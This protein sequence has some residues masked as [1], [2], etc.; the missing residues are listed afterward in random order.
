MR[1]DDAATSSQLERHNSSSSG[2]PPQSPTG[3]SPDQAETRAV[4]CTNPE[5]A[6]IAAKVELI[7]NWTVSK[8]KTSKQSVLEQLGKVEK[9]I[10][11]DMDNR[12]ATLY[13]LRNRY[14]EI[15]H[16][17]T[18]YSTHF[19]TLNNANKMLAESFYQ[20]SLR[21][22][23]LKEALTG[24]NE[25]L[26]QFALHADEF[27]KQLAYFVSSMETLCN[28]TI[29]DT[30]MTVQIYENARLEYDAHRHEL[31]L[32]Q[33]SPERKST[34]DLQ[35]KCETLR[36]K[37]EQLKEDVRVKLALLDENRLKVMRAQLAHFEKGLQQYFTDSIK[38]LV[39]SSPTVEDN[40]SNFVRGVAPRGSSSFLEQ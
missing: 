21:E 27:S 6:Q 22:G 35:N 14:R 39:Q 23:D 2:Q 15:L 30:L 3:V 37:Y 29:Q 8:F 24:R 31:T 12:I 5:M 34:D 10:D 36:L 26:R 25:V 20:L 7:K 32:S 40:D 18:A 17:A 11:V 1:D 33:Q 28:K 4:V 9:T 19:N 38:A 13:D 16:A